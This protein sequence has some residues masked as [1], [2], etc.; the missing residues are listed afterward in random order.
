MK[1]LKHKKVKGMVKVL[2]ALMY[3]G[4]MV[5]IRM[6]GDT[7]F[8]YLLEYNGEIY[9]SYIIIKPQENKKRLSKSEIQECAAL[10]YTGAEATL[11]LLLGEN[12]VDEDTKKAVELMER[13]REIIDGNK[14]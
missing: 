12:T 13:N 9:S 10:I 4:H 8:E 3:K 14:Q 7:Y 5:Y 11:D 2:K 1:K 6:I